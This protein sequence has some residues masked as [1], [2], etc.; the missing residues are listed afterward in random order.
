[1]RSGLRRATLYVKGG[2][3]LLTVKKNQRE[4]KMGVLR[5]R[6]EFAVALVRIVYAWYG[7]SGRKHEQ[8]AAN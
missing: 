5:N 3:Y 7:L 4:I 6:L 2:D 1:M 8:T